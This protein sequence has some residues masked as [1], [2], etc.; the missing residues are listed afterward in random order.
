MREHTVRLSFDVSENEH[1]WLKSE[2]ALLR[3][4]IRDFLHEAMLK[5]LE[6]VSK[7]EL[8]KRLDKALKQS[9][10]GKL[11]DRGSF[12]KYLDNEV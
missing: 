8:H 10:E 3:K 12:A 4:S 9:K 1:V 5:S 7:K 6:D 2:C 11:I